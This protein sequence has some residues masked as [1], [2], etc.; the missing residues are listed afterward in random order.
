VAKTAVV[1]I[2]RLELLQRER[3]EAKVAPNRPGRAPKFVITN[4]GN[5]LIFTALLCFR[6]LLAD[7]QIQ[8]VTMDEFMHLLRCPRS[9][10][11]LV[12]HNCYLF[13]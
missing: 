11:F 6:I 1:K 12:V 10:I 4:P 8:A 13:S 3:I 7:T 2:I 9:M 5:Q